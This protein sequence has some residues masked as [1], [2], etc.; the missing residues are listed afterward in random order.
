MKNAIFTYCKPEPSPYFTFH[1]C[2]SFVLCGLPESIPEKRRAEN[3]KHGRERPHF[4]GFNPPK[5]FPRSLPPVSKVRHGTPPDRSPNRLE[6]VATV[7]HLSHANLNESCIKAC[8]AGP[9]EGETPQC[10][11]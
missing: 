6:C 7:Q 2:N 9:Q 1:L 5:K 4:P 10:P 8:I 11:S 3:Y